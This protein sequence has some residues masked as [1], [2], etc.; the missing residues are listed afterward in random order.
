MM[1]RPPISTRTD[2][3]FPY[4]TRFRSQISMV[5]TSITSSFSYFRC[6]TALRR[7]D[8]I[9]VQ[10]VEVVRLLQPEPGQLE[11]GFARILVREEMEHAIDQAGSIFAVP[12]GHEAVDPNVDDNPVFAGPDRKSTRLNSSH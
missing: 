2:S 11:R 12:H 5:A 10:R 6:R 1:R 4:T 7:R 8:K 9:R 3:L